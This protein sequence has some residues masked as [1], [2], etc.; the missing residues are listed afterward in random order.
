M[1][2]DQYL[3]ASKGLSDGGWRTET[4]RQNFAQIVE[5]I[6]MEKAMSRAGFPFISIDFQ[7]GYWRKENAIHQWFVDNCQDGVDDCR[8]SYVSRE[9]L[10]ELRSICERVLNDNTLA[11]E[12]LP[13]QSGFFFGSTEYDEWYFNGLRDTVD[14]I[15]HCLA[16]VDA[17]CSFFYQ[18]SW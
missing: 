7:V 14:I 10:Q 3:Y 13:T 16:E 15:D 5:A 6:G 17:D 12:L 1:G 2:L 9:K 4:E 11:D 8:K 18:S